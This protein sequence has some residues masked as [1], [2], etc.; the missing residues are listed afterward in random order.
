MGESKNE[1]NGFIDNYIESCE[2]LLKA[3]PYNLYVQILG[4]Q[5]ISNV[6]ALKEYIKNY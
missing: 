3:I 5:H 2:S 4:T 1:C 6:N